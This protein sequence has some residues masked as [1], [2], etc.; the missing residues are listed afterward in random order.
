MT[1]FDDEFFATGP[2]P[3]G[4]NTF[5]VKNGGTP[6]FVLGVGGFG[7]AAGAYGETEPMAPPTVVAGV[8]GAG[9]LQRGVFGFSTQNIGVQGSS[10]VGSAVQGGSFLGGGVRGT[11]FR[12]VGASG[13]SF[14]ASGVTGVSGTQG[15]P[16]PN[17]PAAGVLGSSADRPGVIGTSNT[18]AG[19]HAFSNFVGIVA[20]TTNAAS[21]AG[22]FR[23][24]VVHGTLTANVKNSVVTFPDRTQRV[25]H[26]MESPEHWFE[27]FGA[28]K[29]KAGRVVVKIDADFARVV[30]LDEYHVFVTPADDCRGLCVRNKTATSFEVRELADGKSSV[31]FS[32][33]IVARRKDIKAHKR[34]AKIDTRQA[35][36]ARATRPP[37][38]PAPTAAALREFVAQ[39]EKEAK[40]G[41]RPLPLPTDLSKEFP[42]SAAAS[43]KVAEKK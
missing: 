41:G 22:I 18:A 23:G 1:T 2:A 26:C 19:V 12:G 42:V 9:N 10:F 27:D 5:F 34:F 29:L 33:R 38:E 11:S 24:N 39:L 40:T 32:Y 4:L 6:S 30:K 36:P 14:A 21:F 15:P 16:V 13:Q 43:P 7:S 3:T 28:A 25:L 31:A 20:E 8:Y 17:L 35:L 37:R